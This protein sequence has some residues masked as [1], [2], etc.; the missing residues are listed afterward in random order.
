MDD[1]YSSICSLFVFYTYMGSSKPMGSTSRLDILWGSVDT[2]YG[3]DTMHFTL[4]TFF[5]FG[6][7]IITW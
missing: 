2:L 6:V 5:W 3:A 7:S 4:T 1:C